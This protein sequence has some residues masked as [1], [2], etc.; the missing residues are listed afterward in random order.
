MI[1]KALQL[2]QNLQISFFS[3]INK[4]LE[5][6]RDAPTFNGLPVVPNHNHI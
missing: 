3:L 1:F 4:D 6:L 2:V 5:H